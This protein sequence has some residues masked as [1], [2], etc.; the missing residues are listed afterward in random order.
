M[1]TRAATQHVL[2]MRLIPSV[3]YPFLLFFIL[4]NPLFA[5]L[6]LTSIFRSLSASL[7][8]P[9]FT[10]NQSEHATS[11]HGSSVGKFVSHLNYSGG[12]TRHIY[13]SNATRWMTQVSGFDFRQRLSVLSEAFRPD[14]EPTSLLQNGYWGC[15]IANTELCTQIPRCTAYFTMVTSIFSSNVVL[16]TLISKLIPNIESNASFQPLFSAHSRVHILTLYLFHFLELYPL[17]NVPLPR[18]SGRCLGILKK[19]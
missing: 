11:N 15:F 6:L 1:T 4:E 10:Y 16:P 17:S 3:F 13:M 9:I 19:K 7:I 8:P 12:A 2:P 18:T 14:L 5:L